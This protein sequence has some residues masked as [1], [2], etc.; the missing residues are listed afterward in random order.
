MSWKEKRGKARERWRGKWKKE[1]VLTGKN[2]Q[3]GSK[4]AYQ[5]TSN[6]MEGRSGGSPSNRK[7]KVNVRE[8][9]GGGVVLSTP[10][11][12]AQDKED[13]RE[14]MLGKEKGRATHEATCRRCQV[15]AAGMMVTYGGVKRRRVGGFSINGCRSPKT[16]LDDLCVN[17]TIL[18]P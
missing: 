15:P 1:R 8:A 9:D 18:S 16:V 7:L 17:P 10:T 2:A 12:E 6:Q 4:P 14:D 13:G 11:I 3:W 5:L